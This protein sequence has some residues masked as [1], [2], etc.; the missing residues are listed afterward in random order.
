MLS[1]VPDYQQHYS[2]YYNLYDEYDDLQAMVQ[3][4]LYT[5]NDAEQSYQYCRGQTN[6]SHH[7]LV[8][9]NTNPNSNDQL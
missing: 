6:R 7:T 9:V 2:T 3:Y 8:M 1:A 5:L 4:V